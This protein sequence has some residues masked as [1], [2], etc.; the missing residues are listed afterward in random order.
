GLALLAIRQNELAAEAAGIN[1]RQ[2]KMRALITSGAIAAAAGGLYACVLL[3]VTPE[4][5]FGMLVSA[6]ALVVALFGGVGT[7]WGPLIGSAIL[8]PLSETLQAELGEIIPGIQGVVYGA[9]II[10]IMLLAPE[11]LFWSIRDRWWR[12]RPARAAAATTPA[13]VA[14]PREPL[15]APSLSAATAP[16]LE[17]RG[18]AKSFGG[19]RAVDN[20][21]FSVARGSVLG[22]IGPNGAGK[23]TMFN[24]VNGVLRADA[25]EARVDGQ[26]LVGRPL[27]EVCRLGVGRTFQVVRSFPRLPLLDNVLVGAY[28]AGLSDREAVPAAHAAIARTGL[29]HQIGE[30]A[31]ALTNKELRLMELARALAGRPRLLLLDETLAGLGHDECDAVL[32]VLRGLRAEGMTIVIIEHTMHAMLRIAD[33]LLV[34]DRGSVLAQGMPQAVVE[35]RTVIEAYLGRKWLARCST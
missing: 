23:T 25:G 26:P 14:A 34:I 13:E 6:Q 28:G 33:E 7:Y 16:L 8:I 15:P 17:V 9:A 31:G 30:M 21:S 22:I 18:L 12:R 24:V 3:V 29:S 1:A 20:V 32:D 10:L 11:G 35:D 19:L 2:W 27:H 4:A 5:V